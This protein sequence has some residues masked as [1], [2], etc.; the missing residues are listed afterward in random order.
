MDVVAHTTR[1]RWWEFAPEAVLALGLTYFFFDEMDAATRAV[2]SGRA[3]TVM[4]VV[5][6]ACIAGRFRLTRL[7]RWPLARLAP[8]AAGAAVILAVVV[9]PAYREHR[10]VERLPVE[11]AT[12]SAPPATDTGP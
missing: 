9:L 10:V 6:A 2:K 4:I 11:V 1:L 12:E 5:G 8:F 7:T 3:G